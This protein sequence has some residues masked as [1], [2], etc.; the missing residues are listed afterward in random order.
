MMKLYYMNSNE[1]K[2]KV[3]SKFDQRHLSFVLLLVSSMC[4]CLVYY[5]HLLIV[6]YT[7]HHHHQIVWVCWLNAVFSVSIIIIWSLN[8]LKLL[9]TNFWFQTIFSFNFIE[10][11]YEF[12][13][14]MMFNVNSNILLHRKFA[15][16]SLTSLFI[17]CH[18]R[19]KSAFFFDFSSSPSSSWYHYVFVV[20]NYPFVVHWYLFGVLSCY[21]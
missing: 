15:K 1:R 10:G 4:L 12:F 2:K 14:V 6:L 17:C 21:Q 18:I 13:F 20:Q 16:Y 9:G 11:E 8:D 7:P 3:N 5:Y 19:I